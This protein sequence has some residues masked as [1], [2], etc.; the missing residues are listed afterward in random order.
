MTKHFKR[1]LSDK[2][3]IATLILFLIGFFL[4]FYKLSEFVTFLGD[5]GRDAIV[6][7]RILTLEHLPAIGA[8]TSVGQ[9][10]LGPFYYYFIAPWLLLF[11]FDPIG[12]AVGVAFLSS[13]F[14][15]INYFL[16]QDLFDKK[17]ALFSTSLLTF[18]AVIIDFSHYSWN[19]NLQPLFSLLFVYFFIKTLKSQKV[20]FYLLS[21][22]F[23]SFLVQLHYLAL[24]FI[25]P[26]FLLF[27]ISIFDQK[28]QLKKMF[29]GGLLMFL[30]FSFFSTPLFIFDLRH[31]FLNSKN[32]IQLLKSQ[33]ATATGRV[34]N[35]FSTFDRLNQFAFNFA[36]NQYLSIALLIS[37]FIL[38]LVLFRKKGS[39][40]AFSLFF[41][42]LLAGVSLYAGPKYGHYFNSIYPL[43][44]VLIAYFL[45]LLTTPIL[46]PFL[47]VFFLA[48]FVILNSQSYFFFY[49]KGLDQIERAKKIAK[50]IEENKTKE[51]YS[52]TALPV[53]ASD[54]MYRYFLEI[55]GVRPIEKDSRE[56]AEELFVVCEGQCQPIGHPQW[57]IAYFAAR[58]IE[59]TWQVE[60]VKIYKL[61]R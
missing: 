22:A 40:F 41:V 48:S 24:Y 53:T 30:S 20:V 37:I 3:F 54:S 55:W 9:V 33:E 17:I 57:D 38:L 31:Q 44:F 27:L 50:K 58:K 51:K 43:Y 56:R 1:L 23:L 14:I 28:G 6:I 47:T 59:A 29:K 18:S 25:P 4:R 8:P 60:D 21:G 12:L 19:P 15:L 16:V 36:I 7:K 10:Y 52:I 5:Q 11:N 26:A 42:M 35:L 49:E 34:A 45:S 46:G 2:Y 32:F 61:V 39:A 13:L